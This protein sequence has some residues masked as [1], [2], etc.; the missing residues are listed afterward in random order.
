[1]HKKHG[2]TDMNP[3]RPIKKAYDSPYSDIFVTQ[4]ILCIILGI[5]LAVINLFYPKIAADLISAIT[6]YTQD[7]QDY[8]KHLMD[9][10]G[11]ALQN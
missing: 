2:G 11:A 10:I 7:T 4:S 8:I 6:V 1:M 5:A 9:I 3:Q